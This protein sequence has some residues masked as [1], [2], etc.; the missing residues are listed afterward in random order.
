MK[1]SLVFSSGLALA[2][3]FIANISAVGGT[4]SAPYVA[5]SMDGWAGPNSYSMT[6]TFLG[7]DIWTTS[8]TGLTPGGRYE[9]KI[10]DGTW[11]LSLPGANSWFFADGSG[12]ITITYDGNTYADGW[13]TTMDRLPLPAYSD[14][15]T[16]NAVGN[17][18]SQVGGGDWDNANVNTLMTPLGGGIYEFSAT[19][20]PGDYLWKAVVNG[21][22]D[23]ISWDSRSV[24]TADWAFTTTVANPTVT[25]RVDALTGVAQ[26]I[27]P[28]PTT[29]ALA[30][31]GL[32]ALITLR[33]RS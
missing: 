9:F 18:Q 15:G 3:L 33:R 22:W 8:I 14:P 24:G 30:G 13:S 5:G 12:D 20:A 17:W 28:E 6:E 29:F 26:I 7:S 21:S 2:G 31:L 19:L 27:V 25:F 32:A 11:G 10:T 16:W 1:Q 4:I 23:S